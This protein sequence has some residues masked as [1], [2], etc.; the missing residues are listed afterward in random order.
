MIEFEPPPEKTGVPEEALMKK[1]AYFSLIYLT[2]LLFLATGCKT[3]DEAIM[4]KFSIQETSGY[5][6]HAIVT[7]KNKNSENY[8][9]TSINLFAAIRNQT[10]LPGTITGWSF[11]I[12]RDIVTIVEINQSNYPNFKL[13]ISGTGVVPADEIMEFNVG[14]PQPFLLN[15]LPKEIFTFSPYIPSQVIA[16]IQITAEDG[17]IYN[18]TAS[19]TYTFEETTISENQP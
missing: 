14:T 4:E 9:L 3:G 1:V 18:I 6:L 12:K 15:A 8:E 17:M 5:S 11:K 19:G 7:P 10:D 13:A 2:P 16:E